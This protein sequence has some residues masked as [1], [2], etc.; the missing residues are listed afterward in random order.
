VTRHRRRRRPFLHRWGTGDDGLGRPSSGAP[1]PCSTSPH[2]DQVR[3][4]ARNAGR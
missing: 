4:R 2:V 3:D 1:T